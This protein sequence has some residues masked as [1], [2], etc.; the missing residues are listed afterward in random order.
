MDENIDTENELKKKYICENIVKLKNHKNYIDIV[1][2]HNCPHT[3]NSNGLFLNLNTIDACVIDKLY[4]KLKNEIEND[5]LSIN[6]IEK[7]IIE[8]EIDK[9]LKET[10]S[11][12]KEVYDIIKMEDF[13]EEEQSI[14]NISKKYK[15]D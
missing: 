8:N 7:Q 10:G 6:I 1:K 14:I 13:T 3:N 15:F 9:L 12:I 2:F 5:D 4:Y 11:N